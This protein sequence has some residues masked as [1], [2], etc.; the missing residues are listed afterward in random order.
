MPCCAQVNQLPN[1]NQK[2]LMNYLLDKMLLALAVDP[3]CDTDF[4]NGELQTHY[5]TL[6]YYQ[7][8]PT[9]SPVLPGHLRNMTNGP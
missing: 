6:R 9:Y 1:L 2:V 7:R 3:K 4:I 5:D 8:H